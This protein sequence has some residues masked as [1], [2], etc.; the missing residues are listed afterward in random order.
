M[1]DDGDKVCLGRVINLVFVGKQGHTQCD[2]KSCLFHMFFAS[3]IHLRWT[4][5]THWSQQGT[6][7][8]WLCCIF[9]SKKERYSEKYWQRKF[10]VHSAGFFPYLCTVLSVFMRNENVFFPSA[11]YHQMAL[12]GDLISTLKRHWAN[13]KSV[14]RTKTVSFHLSSTVFFSLPSIFLK[15]MALN[16]SKLVVSFYHLSRWYGVMTG[17][18][19]SVQRESVKK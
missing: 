10:P 12:M 5:A 4:E 3:F 13:G 9:T 8:I 1:H 18:P 6:A 2:W 7:A 14:I 19:L 17:P 16:V 15:S 11:V